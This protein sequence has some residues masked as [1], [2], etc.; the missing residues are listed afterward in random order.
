MFLRK[1][2]VPCA[3]PYT[4]YL[5]T[6]SAAASLSALGGTNRIYSRHTNTKRCSIKI[7][8]KWQFA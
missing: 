1:P 6:V 7:N 8:Q 3:K 5:I 4:E 2:E